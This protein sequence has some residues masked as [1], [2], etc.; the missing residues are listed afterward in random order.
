MLNKLFRPKWQHPVESLRL[1]AI[2]KLGNNEQAI[3]E[4][5]ARN[6][7]S[8]AVRH[9]ATARIDNLQ[10]LFQLYQQTPYSSDRDFIQ[11]C[12]CAILSDYDLTSPE[13]AEHIILGCKDPL[14]LAAIAI[15]SNNDSHQELALTGLRDEKAILHVI[16]NTRHSHLWQQLIKQLESEYALKQAQIITKDR[17][18]RSQQ[19]IRQKLDIL[20][21]Q[22]TA[23]AELEQ[24]VSGLA[25]KLEK[26]ASDPEQ[27]HFEGLLLSLEQQW[28][29]LSGQYRGEHEAAIIQSLQR[30]RTYLSEQQKQQQ[31]EQLAQQQS[32]EIEVACQALLQEL[33]ELPAATVEQYQRFRQ[34]QQDAMALTD[35]NSASMSE[36]DSL[37]KTLSELEK[38]QALKALKTDEIEQLDSTSIQHKLD[39][40]RQAI[41]LC[42]KHPISEQKLVTD[43]VLIEE[44]LEQHLQQIQG[45]NHEQQEKILDWIASAD[46]AIADDNLQEARRL[47]QKIR[48]TIEHCN[49]EQRSHYSTALQRIQAATRRL[50]DWQTFATEPKR[51]ELCEEMQK[52][53][54]ADIP[55]QHKA[56]AIHDL[57]DQWKALGFCQDQHLWQTFRELGQQAYQPCKAYFAEQKQ[58]KAFNAEQRTIICEQIELLLKNIDWQDCDY[59]GMEKLLKATG[60]EWNKYSPVDNKV[61]KS[62]QKRYYDSINII[63]KQLNNERQRNAEKLQ[64]I[65]A[66]ARSLNSSAHIEQAILDY[67]QLHDKWKQVGICHRK[68]QQQLWQELREAGNELYTIREQQHQHTEQ[69]RQDNQQKAE[70]LINEIRNAAGRNQPSEIDIS[71]I[72]KTF[73]ELGPLPEKSWRQTENA[74][75]RACDDYQNA[76]KKAEQTLY[77]QQFAQVKLWAENCLEQEKSGQ[78][79]TVAVP[80]DLPEAWQKHLITRLQGEG[81]FDKDQY[82][83]LC[84]SLEILCEQASPDSDAALRMQMQVEKLAERFGKTQANDANTR[85]IDAY[86]QWSAL[87]GDASEEYQLLSQRFYQ[88]ADTLLK[89]T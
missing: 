75:N 77:Y 60:N 72:K 49:E 54:D 85:F 62:L 4:Q 25:E 18:K 59:K 22:K 88:L 63:R 66:E 67:R 41:N 55:P 21:Q 16:N 47:H 24:Q 14:W 76:C 78:T 80:G 43:F 86:L 56:A 2:A 57:Q 89:Q 51:Q 9:A 28:Q 74:F 23:A 13:R 27:L 7:E 52:L 87:P 40:T 8:E 37:L 53:I 12:W 73:Q 15:Y 50:Q 19:L 68:Q 48:S 5:I 39:E 69:M 64:Q 58:N 70:S 29:S 36:L 17:D 44:Q 71:P 61:H 33:A 79:A 38:F 31:Q 11:Q 20:S 6:D 84:I 65:V 35:S 32:L 3:F 1:Q 46:Q 10:L 30:C 45:R 82:R 83:R 26:L 81:N 34:L 42:R